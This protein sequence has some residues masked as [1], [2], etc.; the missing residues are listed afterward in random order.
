MPAVTRNGVRIRY[1]VEGDGPPLVLHIGGIGGALEDW[2]DAGYAAALKDAFQLILSDP[3]GQGQSDKPHEPT[4]Y[5]R[6][7]RVGDVCAV[8]DAVGVERAHF[9][10]YSLGGQ[11][12]YGLG[13]F[14]ANR[15]S[16][17]ILGGAS[18]DP[19]STTVEEF[20]LYQLLQPGMER[21]VAALEDDDPD[22]WASAGD[23][24]RP[25]PSPSA[26]GCGAVSAIPV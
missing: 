7:E 4:A 23:G 21:M 16:S 6:I 5:T 2:Y 11:V 17:L 25:T 20:P 24:W 10:G 13:V 9:W 18:P 22:Y 3:R 1:E 26:P 14:A 8:L 12:G 19:P 15:V